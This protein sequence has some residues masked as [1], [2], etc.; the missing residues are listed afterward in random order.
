MSI[1]KDTRELVCQRAKCK[2]EYC[3]ISETDAGGLLTIDHYKPQTKGGTDSPEN[4]VY[5]CHR[6]NLYKAYYY[7]ENPTDPTIWNPRKNNRAKHFFDL[8][9]ANFKV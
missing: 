4:L 5:C 6:C 2:C 3:E 1:N 8:M 7:P 9:M